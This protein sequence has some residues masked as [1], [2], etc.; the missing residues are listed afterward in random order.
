MWLPVTD[1]ER[2]PDAE[3]ARELFL[4]LYRAHY[5]RIVAYARRRTDS[6]EDAD[7]VAAATFE[8]A[9]QRLDVLLGADEP[10]AWLYGVTRRTVLSHYRD[11]DK[12][13]LAQRTEAETSVLYESIE[14]SFETRDDLGRV[15]AAARTLSEKDQEILRLVGWEGSS[16]DEIAEILGIS[17]MLVRTRIKRARHRLRVAYAEQEGGSGTEGDG[18]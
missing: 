18:R 7:E 16:R 4:R 3:E 2:P 6:I 10:L 12:R 13:R 8:I 5:H 14:E 1:H 9:W 15:I 11:M 17:R